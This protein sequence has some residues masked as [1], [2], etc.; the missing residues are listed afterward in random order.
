MRSIGTGSPEA[1]VYVYIINSMCAISSLTSQNV[2]RNTLMSH[3][4]LH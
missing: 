3:T 4:L 2:L 1:I